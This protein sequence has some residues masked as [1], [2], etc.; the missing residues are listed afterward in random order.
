MQDRTAQLEEAFT[1]L[2]PGVEADIRHLP[3]PEIA[4]AARQAMEEG[5]DV[6]AAAGG[7]GTVNQVA[8]VTAGTGTPLAVLPMGTLNHFARDAGIPFDLREAAAVAVQGQARRVDVAEVNGCLFVN[9]SSIGVYPRAVKERERRR[10]LGASKERSTLAAAWGVLRRVPA[11]HVVLSVDGEPMRRTTSFVFVGNNPYE[12]AF[13]QLGRRNSLNGGK[14]AIYH[15][16][17]AT[18]AGL[19]RLA[20]HSLLGRL[21]E[22]RDLEVHEAARLTIHSPRESLRTAVD[23]EVMR[24]ASPL[25]YRIRP[26]HLLLMAPRAPTREAEVA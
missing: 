16:R 2:G 1:S 10:R 17:H 26:A 23:G 18:R 11:H 7:D 4:A 5:A 24:L 19:L 12:T 20:F 3:P 25:Q 8:S 22:A 6:I 13:G 14:L 9:N 15:A 21:D